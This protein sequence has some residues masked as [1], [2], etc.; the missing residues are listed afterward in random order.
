MS[1]SPAVRKSLLTLAALVVWAVVL[2]KAI[3]AFNPAGSDNNV[4]FNSDSAIVVLMANDDRPITVFNFYYYCADRWG[5]WQFVLAQGIRRA[6]GFVWTPQSVLAMQAT[7]VLLGAWAFAG[8]CRRDWVIA[9]LAYLVAACV[10]KEGRLMLFELS[11]IYGWQITGLVF[12]WLGIRRVF[13]CVIPLAGAELT[14]APTPVVPR[15]RVM[16]MAGWAAVTIV[17]GLLSIWSSV[18]SIPLLLVLWGIEGVRA[19]ARLM[20]GAGGRVFRTLAIGSGVAIVAV[21]IAAVGERAIKNWYHRWSIAHYG[22]DFSTH[23]NID[24]GHLLDSLGRQLG[25]IFGLSWWPLYALPLLAILALAAL[26]IAAIVTRRPD[27]R[28]RAVAILADDTAMVV[29]GAFAIAVII[30]TL[31]VLVDHVR[32]NDYDSRYLTLTNTFGPIAGILTL[33]LAIRWWL[34]AR[35]SQWRVEP[36]FAL[37]GVVVL[38]FGF[39]RGEETLHYR[40]HDRI[41]RTLAERAP[42]GVLMGG[43]WETYVFTALQPPE[44]AMTPV[45]W[46][47]FSRTPWT[48]A[49]L[50]PAREVIVVYAK[51][52]GPRGPSVEMP[53]T[54]IQHG[55]TL[56][57]ADG[58][59]LE[60]DAYQFGRYINPAPVAQ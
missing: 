19:W 58:H 34:R 47:G 15:V 14:T 9:G 30:F 55:V 27:L 24:Y 50:A 16:A 4:S 39:P 59:W 6:T 53:P 26:S 44:R 21:I 28:T 1:L 49:A 2:L 33:Y 18:A 10:H 22:Q 51:T 45:L 25:H 37:V 52:G 17:F 7:W 23:F 31:A 5:A 3:D 11:Q 20:S 54:M 40:T 36:T 42:R 32:L 29:V 56:T 57:L 8:L 48:P 35:P 60:S 46:E 13:D 43:Y 41:A 38:A 12:A